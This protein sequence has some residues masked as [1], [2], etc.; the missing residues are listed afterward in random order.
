MWRLSVLQL[1]FDSNKFNEKSRQPSND[2]INDMLRL[3]CMFWKNVIIA[4][5]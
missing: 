3:I 5:L 4:A 1:M 2:Q